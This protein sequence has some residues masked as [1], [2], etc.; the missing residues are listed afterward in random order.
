VVSISLVN[1][2]ATDLLLAVMSELRCVCFGLLS[3]RNAGTALRLFAL[4]AQFSS[5]P[6]S[7]FDPA[8]GDE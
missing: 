5:L 8:S 6:V 3:G 7:L 4:A 2:V 1:T